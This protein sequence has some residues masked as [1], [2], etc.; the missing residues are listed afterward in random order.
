[1]K[2]NL[3]K[4]V[5][6]IAMSAAVMCSTFSTPSVVCAAD[7]I[8]DTM[9]IGYVKEEGVRLRL[10]GN[11]EDDVILGIMSQNEVVDYY[12]QRYG[13]SYDFNYVRRHLNNTYG[14]VHHDYIRFN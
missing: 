13:D 3:M 11:W 1:M 14:Y 4:M 2:K 10:R 9:C 7:W 5:L 6:G 12:E 8:D